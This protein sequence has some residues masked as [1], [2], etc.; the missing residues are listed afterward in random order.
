MTATGP[1][2]AEHNLRTAGIRQ[3]F[4]AV[5]CATMV[6]REA[7]PDVYAYACHTLGVTPEECYA[8]EDS[9]NGVR[10]AH[11]AGCRVIM[12]PDLT[13]PDAELS[14]KLL[15]RKAGLFWGTYKYAC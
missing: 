12:I 14:G 5:I 13:Q 6:E 11:D 3:Y 15:H 10:S 1:E 4:D 2:Q 9:P 8:V 7:A